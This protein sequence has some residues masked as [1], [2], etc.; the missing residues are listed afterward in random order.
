ME[1]IKLLGY[2]FFTGALLGSVTVGLISLFNK[3][4][5]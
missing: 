3:E 4:L 5:K 2:I 1:F